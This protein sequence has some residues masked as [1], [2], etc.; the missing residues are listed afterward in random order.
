MSRMYNL[1][2]H[3]GSLPVNYWQGVDIRSKIVHFPSQRFKQRRFFVALY[4]FTPKEWPPASGIFDFLCQTA[5]ETSLT[6]FQRPF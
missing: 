1:V 3:I 6:G 5:L 4:L 2:G